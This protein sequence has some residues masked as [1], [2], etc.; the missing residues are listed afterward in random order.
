MVSRLMSVLQQAFSG[1]LQL[2]PVSSRS[3]LLSGSFISAAHP[4]VI[5]AIAG[6]PGAGKS[7]LAQSVANALNAV[8]PESAALLSMDDYRFDD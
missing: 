6:A 7:S 5:T 1:S 4:R 2:I 8:D 3:K